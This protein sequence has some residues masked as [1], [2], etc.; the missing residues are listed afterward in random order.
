MARD[1][2]G[3]GCEVQSGVAATAETRADGGFDFTLPPP[4]SAGFTVYFATADHLGVRYFGPPLHSGD[5]PGAYRIAVYDTV[6]V[7]APPS[8]IRLAS[9]DVVLLPQ[10]DGGWEVNEI[11]QLVNDEQHTFVAPLGTPT[12]EFRI[13]AEA[14]A[15]EVGEG[16]TPNSEVV[17]MGERVLLTAPVVP[18]ARELFLRYRVPAGRKPLAYALPQ[19]AENFTLFVRQPAPTVAVQGLA[20]HDTVSSDGEQFL[21]YAGR[22]LAAGTTVQIESRGPRPSP[23]KPV[24]AAIAMV[25]VVLAGGAWAAARGR[26]PATA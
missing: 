26:P 25:V 13:P 11:V 23:V 18:G 5:S 17:R 21:R 2:S 22:E 19:A 9:R 1:D 8:A 7:A 4:D 14:E 10:S 16:E 24:H 12:W 15:F 20:V 6:E 3:A